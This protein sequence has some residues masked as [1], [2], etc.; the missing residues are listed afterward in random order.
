M[1]FTQLFLAGIKSINWFDEGLDIA[2]A[3]SSGRMWL[4]GG[5]VYRS[6]ANRLYG[7]PLPDKTDLDFAVESAAEEFKLP[8]GWELKT[9]RL[10][11]PRFVNGK[12][13]I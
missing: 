8:G 11:G 9:T 2:K 1:D 4:V 5:A 13:Q 10:G 3:N 6:I 12:R 7:T